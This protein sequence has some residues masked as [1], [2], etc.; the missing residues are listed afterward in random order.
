MLITFSA[1]NTKEYNIERGITP[2]FQCMAITKWFANI[3]LS[4][5]NFTAVEISMLKS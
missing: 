5:V 2:F 3:Y 4:L 1:Q